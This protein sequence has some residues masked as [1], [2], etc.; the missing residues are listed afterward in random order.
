MRSTIWITALL[1]STVAFAQ[2]PPQASAPASQDT[3]ITAEQ[4]AALLQ[5]APVSKDTGKPGSLSAQLFGNPK[6]SCAFI[7]INEPD[8]PHAHGVT[9]E[10]LIIQSGEGTLETGGDMVGPFDAN[11]DVH[12]AF[13]VGGPRT[14]TAGSAPGA[15]GSAAGRSARGPG[16]LRM[17]TN[18]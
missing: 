13:F 15:T 2:A 10:V 7:R 4:L 5:N 11:S 6:V 16:R 8:K 17:R 14:N 1:F 18:R 3:L 9:S 12:T